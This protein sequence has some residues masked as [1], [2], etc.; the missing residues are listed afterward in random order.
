M[1]KIILTLFIILYNTRIISR[2]NIIIIHKSSIYT[3]LILLLLSKN[4]KGKHTSCKQLFLSLKF[5]LLQMVDLETMYSLLSEKH[6]EL[7]R[8]YNC[9][10]V[11]QIKDSS[12][13]KDKREIQRLSKINSDLL[14][15]VNKLQTQLKETM[16]HNELLEFRLLELEDIETTT[17]VYYAYTI[18]LV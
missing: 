2:Y 7:L 5:H 10:Q 3:Y 4:K 16:E 1:K 12:L 17:K 6:S 11:Q 9:V 14:I 8:A 18:I 15:E 13:R